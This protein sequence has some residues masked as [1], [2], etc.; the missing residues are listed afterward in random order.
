MADAASDDVFEHYR[1][2]AEHLHRGFYFRANDAGARVG[3]DFVTDAETTGQETETA[4]TVEL[5]A[6]WHLG[7]SNY[8][9]S[10]HAGRELADDVNWTNYGFGG[11]DDAFVVRDSGTDP[12]H[13][14]TEGSDI[15][16]SAT[17]VE[18]DETYWIRVRNDVESP[19][20]RE[21][22][23]STFTEADGVQR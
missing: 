2:E 1:I 17:V 22:V 9:V 21:I 12:I 10:A 7:S 11:G 19:L 3:F 20:V 6:G 8:D 23:S 4:P 16:G 15:D 5:E 13:D 14:M 18:H